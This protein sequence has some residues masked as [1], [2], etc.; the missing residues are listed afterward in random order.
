MEAVILVNTPISNIPPMTSKSA[1]GMRRS[2]GSP[3]LIIKPGLT[4]IFSSFGNPATI[5]AIILTGRG[6][7]LDSFL[8]LVWSGHEEIRSTLSTS[9]VEYVAIRIL[10]PSDFHITS[11]M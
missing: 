6:P 5:P 11:N 9:N 3:R 8:K 4:E 2:G 10:E 1:I 7:K